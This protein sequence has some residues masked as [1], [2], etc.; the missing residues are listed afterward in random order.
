MKFDEEKKIVTTS[1]F[2]IFLRDEFAL[3][4]GI[5]RGGGGKLSCDEV[6]ER[7]PFKLS[8]CN[9]WRHRVLPW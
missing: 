5:V 4:R 1:L 3:Q 8:S 6:V 9:V 2:R 7:I